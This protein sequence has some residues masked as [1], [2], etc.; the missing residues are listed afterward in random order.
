VRLR[1]TARLPYPSLQMTLLERIDA[2][3][4][5]AMKARDALRTSVLRMAKAAIRNRE[6]DARASLEDS[7]VVRVL[8]GL[9][10]QREEAATQ[11]R[12]GRR[13]ELAE[14]EE[15]EIELLRA[16]LPEQA[17]EA[18]LRA[19]VEAAVAAT[20]ASGPTDLGR[21]MKA[22]LADLKTQGRPVDGK[23]LNQLVREKLGG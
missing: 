8:Q 13:E 11:F 18:D 3:L 2:D 5:T 22:A 19:A 6:I 20:G 4:K 21:V 15:A 16:Y 7:E 12:Q 9:V 17:S 1:G 23:K 14:K 10:K